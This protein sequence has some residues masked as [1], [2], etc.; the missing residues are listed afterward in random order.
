MLRRYYTNL[1][2]VYGGASAAA[3]WASETYGAKNPP[4]V[5]TMQTVSQPL[6]DRP[7]RGWPSMQPRPSWGRAPLSMP[8]EGHAPEHE[9]H[10]AGFQL[11]LD[12]PFIMQHAPACAC[13]TRRC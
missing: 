5:L 1:Y 6:S 12:P 11:P 3:V 2:S 9:L 13:A 7:L 8:L 4:F 10:T